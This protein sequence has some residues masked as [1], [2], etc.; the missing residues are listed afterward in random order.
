VTVS[1]T[2]FHFASTG[3]GCDAR[4]G[5]ARSRVGLITGIVI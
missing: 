4:Q 1:Q 5:S 2:S 3:T